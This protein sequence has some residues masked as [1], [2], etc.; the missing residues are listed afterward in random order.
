MLKHGAFRAIPVGLFLFIIAAAFAPPVRAQVPGTELFAK[1]PQTPIELWDAVDYL[2]RTGQIKKALPYLDKFV[3][4]KPDDATLDIIRE[5]YGY[6]SILRLGDDPATRAF[7]EPLTEAMIAAE[8]KTATDPKRI[9]GFVAALSRTTEEQDF[10]VRALRRAGADAVPFVVAAVSRPDVSAEDRRKIWAN[11]ARL[12]HSAMPPL[13]ALLDSGDPIL[14][15]E[16]AKAL[17]A[18]GDKRSIPHLTFPAGSPGADPAVRQA[19]QAAIGRLTGRTF[20]EQQRTPVDVLTDTAWRLHRHQADLGAEPVAIWTWDKERSA[21]VSRKV[22]RTE[23]EAILGERFAK[24]ALVLSPNDRSA[25]VVLLSLNLEKAI[26]RAGY[27][28]FNAKDQP[29]LKTAR[30]AGPALLI[31]ALAS[32]IADGKTDLAAVLA[33]ALGSVIDEKAL[34]AGG[35]PHPLVNA[36]Y[37]PGRRLQFAAA[38]ALVK[39]APAATFPGSSRIVPT[40][41]RFL[42]TQVQSRAIVI[43]ANP[44]RGSQL[45]GFLIELGYDSELELTGAKGFVAAGAAADV[46]LVLISHDL[47][48]Q[49]WALSETLANLTADSHTAAIPVFIYGPRNFQYQHPN[50]ERNY[51]GIRFLVQPVDSA[52]L[53]RQIKNL[54]NELDAAERAAYARESAEMLA[55]LAKKSEDP[56]AVVSSDVERALESALNSTETGGVAAV[57]LGHVAQADAQRALADVVLEPF[58]PSALRRQ[59]AAELLQSIRRFGPLLTRQQEARLKTVIG[60]EGDAGVQTDLEAISRLLRSASATEGQAKPPAKPLPAKALPAKPPE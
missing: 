5:R 34:A 54:P 17:G 21:P 37:G 33:G 31:Q 13:A 3:K 55:G 41:A 25:R 8:R 57:S 51:P 19:A 9:E 28:A 45:A 52:M 7:A 36:L 53:K 29:E 11:A 43:D 22:P 14:A 26:E 4:G 30:A 27:T 50:L 20:P 46:E 56:L 23:A 12:D 32:A 15:A 39:L 49:Q 16:A 59:S 2:L 44:N 47:F 10:A 60:E 40:L 24:D 18:I 42:P 38:K 35:R 1:Q 6:A 48:G 58:R